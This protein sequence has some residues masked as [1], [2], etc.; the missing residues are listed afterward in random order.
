MAAGSTAASLCSKPEVIDLID[1]DATPWEAEPMQ[2]L[3]QSGQLQAFEHAGFWQPWTPCVKK[4]FLEELWQSGKPVEVL[5]RQ[6]PGPPLIFGAAAC[7]ADRA[8]R[9]QRSWLALWLGRMG[10][11]DGLALAP[12]TEPNLFTPGPR[13]D[14]MHASH[15]CDVRDAQAVAAHVQAARPQIVLHLAAQALVRAGYADLAGHPRHQRR[16]ARPMC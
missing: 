8:H 16:W 2:R 5:V 10:G 9:L 4:N 3:A 14:D 11:G 12:A 6:P 7:A 15:V 13:G 1:G